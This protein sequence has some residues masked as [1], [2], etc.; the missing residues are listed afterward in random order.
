MKIKV[1]ILSQDLEGANYQ[2]CNDCPIARA[3]RR[4]FNLRR[5]DVS[6][7]P[8]TFRNHRDKTKYFILDGGGTH[9][10]VERMHLGERNHV[11]LQ[12]CEQS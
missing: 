2:S 8:F 3:I 12:K 4:H 7:G 10:S 11:I 1:M 5:R 9:S 6:V